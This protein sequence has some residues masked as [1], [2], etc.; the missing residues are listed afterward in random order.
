[1]DR[2]NAIRDRRGILVIEDA[3]HAI[4]AEWRGTRIG[5]HGNLTAYSF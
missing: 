3:A 5:G 1:M 4:G 2:V